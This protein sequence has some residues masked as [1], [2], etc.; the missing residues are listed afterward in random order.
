MLNFKQLVESLLLETVGPLTILG[1]GP[2]DATNGWVYL[3]LDEHQ[4][5]FP[6]ATNIP[7]LNKKVA[8]CF[9]QTLKNPPRP[10]KN[11]VRACLPLERLYDIFAT[12]R[13]QTS[14]N[15]ALDAN[16]FLA[17]SS[18]TVA[19]NGFANAIKNSP[20][21]EVTG[22]TKTAYDSLINERD[23][24]AK[25]ALE[26]YYS[27]SILNAVNQI[28]KKRSDAFTRIASLRNPFT[29]GFAKLIE[30]ALLNPEQYASGNKKVTNDF[31]EIVDDLYFKQI[32]QVGIT[33]KTLFLK[34]FGQTTINNTDYKN[35]LQNNVMAP[36][37][38]QK[39]DYTIKG[40]DD[41][42]TEES[43]DLIEALRSIA[44]YERKKA[45]R[46]ERLKYASQAVGALAN[47]GGASLYGGP[48]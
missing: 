29:S 17:N 42:S 15:G 48:S 45:G 43:L 38:G 40:I 1:A 11:S 10:S 33:A 46:G 5:R 2:R 18:V 6:N 37:S 20:D 26:T 35:F 9:S 28:V 31:K 27:L 22:I 21:W 39:P 3:L 36:Q 34:I 8:E 44:L 32:L 19:G 12:I 23:L 47:F 30:D 16:S 14:Y 41:M 4:A 13:N 24:L 7:D 25:A